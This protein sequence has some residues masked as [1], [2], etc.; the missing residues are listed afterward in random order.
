MAPVLLKG[1]P[2]LGR[3]VWEKELGKNKTW[4]GLV[5]AVLMGI[6]VFWLQKYLFGFDFFYDISLIDY[7]DFSLWLGFLLGLGAILGDLVGSYFKRRQRVK[8]GESWMPWE[9]IKSGRATALIL[10]CYIKSGMQL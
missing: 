8:E 3:P 4:R 10:F 2:V 6:L 9:R 7:G 5:A 1:V